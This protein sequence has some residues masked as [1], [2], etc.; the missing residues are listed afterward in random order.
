MAKD[1]WVSI[2][3]DWF[4]VTTGETDGP[5]KNEIVNV[6]QKIEAPN[7]SLY[8]KLE[9]YRPDNCYNSTGFRPVDD[10]FGPAVCERIEEQIEY[11]HVFTEK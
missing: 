6:L 9:G 7:G 8:F 10:T 2:K 5:K 3:D 11:E 4:S 1:L